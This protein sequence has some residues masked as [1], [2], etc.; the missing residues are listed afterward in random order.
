[1]QERV[2]VLLQAAPLSW[3]ARTRD[4][5]KRANEIVSA[6]QRREPVDKL[7]RHVLR[8]FGRAGCYGRETRRY[9][10]QVL[11]PVAHLTG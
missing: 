5:M 4:T 6:A 3:F 9:R 8:R 7:T 1:M 11:D 10:Q 2:N